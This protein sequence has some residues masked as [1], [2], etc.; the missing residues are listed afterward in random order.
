[1]IVGGGRCRLSSPWLDVAHGRLG[2]P[3]PARRRTSRAA[4]GRGAASPDCSPAR[5]EAA[6]RRAG[7]DQADDAGQVV[8]GQGDAADRFYVIAEGEVEVTQ[9]PGRKGEPVHVCAG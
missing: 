9:A 8:I 2:H 3:G 1:M 4:G 7:V 6:E 5:L